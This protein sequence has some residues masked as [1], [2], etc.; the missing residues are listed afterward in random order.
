MDKKFAFQLLGLLILI[1]GALV[2]TFIY[3]GQTP[4]S[5]TAGNIFSSTEQTPLLELKKLDI[6]DSSSINQSDV[7]ISFN[8]EIADEPSERK[9]GLGGRDSLATGSGMLFIFNKADKYKFWMKGMRF[10]LDFIWINDTRVVD[11]LP[12]IK[13]PEPNQPDETLPYLSPIIASD[14]VLEVNAGDVQR[15]NIKVGDKILVRDQVQ[16]Q[17]QQPQQQQFQQ[18]NQ[19]PEQVQPDPN[20]PYPQTY[21]PN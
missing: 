6:I 18:Q 16:E 17:Q 4:F 8:I 7:K 10:P 11:I 9:L 3:R 5:G 2:I 13:Q 19:Q 20:N 14:K 1:F 12:N 21:P 15:Y